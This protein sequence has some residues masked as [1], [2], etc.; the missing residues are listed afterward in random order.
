M[1]LICIEVI[2]ELIICHF[3]TNTSPFPL[4]T[5]PVYVSAEWNLGEIWKKCNNRLDFLLGIWPKN[6]RW[7]ML[8]FFFFFFFTTFG[9]LVTISVNPHENYFFPGS[10]FDIDSIFLLA[11]VY[12]LPNKEVT[13]QDHVLKRIVEA[14][15]SFFCKLCSMIMTSLY[16]LFFVPAFFLG[17][18]KFFF[19]FFFF[20]STTLGALFNPNPF[21]SHQLLN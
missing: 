11:N 5:N 18:Q 3:N 2:V 8:Y 13:Q 16:I 17:W 14:I 9:Y 15:G 20:L 6:N 4:V 12:T 10:F 1:F 21:K 19:S 7:L